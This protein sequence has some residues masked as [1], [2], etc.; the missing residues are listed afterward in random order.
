MTALQLVV[1]L[2]ALLLLYGGLIWLARWRQR[3]QG[4]RRDMWRR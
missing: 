1:F 2:V 4:W 3:K